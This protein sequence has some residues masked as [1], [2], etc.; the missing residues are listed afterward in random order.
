LFAAPD[1]KH[2]YYTGSAVDIAVW[3]RDIEILK[4][5]GCNTIRLYGWNNSLNHTQFLDALL[6]NGIRVVLQYWF[7][8]S[9]D[10]S[11][12]ATR[13]NLINGFTAM[14]N[15]YKYHPAIIMW[16]FGA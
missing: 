8:S 16:L 12:A 11:N 14:V 3:Q 4:N 1:Q 7:P 6:Q 2:D 13:T 9:N 5:M 15:N 10:I